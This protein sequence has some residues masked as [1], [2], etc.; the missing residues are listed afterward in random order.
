MAATEL[1]LTPIH[2]I[3]TTQTVHG[4]FQNVTS[5]LLNLESNYEDLM[6]WGSWQMAQQTPD[7]SQTQLWSG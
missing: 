6:P 3:Q 2:S 5:V 4:C 7:T 1:A